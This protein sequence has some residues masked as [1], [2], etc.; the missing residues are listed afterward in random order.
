ML[1]GHPSER[2]RVGT[3]DRQRRT[4][5]LWAKMLVLFAGLLI[6][7]EIGNLFSVQHVFATFWPP[8][9]LLVAMLLISDRRDWPALVLSAIAANI[10]SDLLHDRALLVS[11]GFSFANSAEALFGA[12]LVSG[13]VGARPRLTTM[14]QNL[15]F[16]LL[17]G[18]LAPALG[19]MVGTVVVVL[20]SPG[21][22]VWTTWYAWLIADSL[23]VVLV[24]SSVLACVGV[25]DAYRE[26]PSM[27][28]RQH[29]RPILLSILVAVPFAVVSHIVFTPMG[30]GTSWKFL[31]SPGIVTCGIVG[32]PAGAAL[33]FTIIAL[34]GVQGMVDAASRAAVMSPELSVQVFQAQA[35]FVV[36]GICILTLAGVIAES[37][38]HAQETRESADMLRK[39][40]NS[41]REGVS[42]GRIIRDSEGVPNDWIVLSTNESYTRLTGITDANGR[43]VSEFMP[44]LVKGN[45]EILETFAAVAD[46]GEAR[47]LETYIA[48]VGK[49]MDFSVTSPRS[50]EFLAVFEDATERVAAEEALAAGN[51]RLEKMVYDVAEAMGSVVEARDPYTQGHQLRVAILVRLIGEEMGL[52]ESELDELAMAA[53]LHDIGKLRV[54]AE[55]L[56]KPGQL[57]P[58]EMSLVQ[59]HPEQGYETLRH[60]D[61]PW[62]IADIVRQHHERMD[63]SGYP[64]GLTGD[65]I[66]PPSRILAAADVIEA[67]AS[68]RPY[69]PAVS[70]EAGVAEVVS[71]PD[72]FDVE[73]TAACQRLL[74]RG[75]IVFPKA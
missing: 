75:A 36:W 51:V 13:V 38:H 12:F 20:S 17:A 53:L 52:S 7:A 9:G 62:R 55:I 33:G 56:N 66:L 54:P 43:R 26:R 29:L 46:D 74:E 6:A 27:R 18:V 64:H 58:V 15:A 41:M 39:L 48:S 67:L 23:G 69:R 37:R 8:A 30:G 2:A 63:G 73:V 21:A 19:A 60:I 16:T 34:A 61:F 5:P 35:F 65:E 57:S 70:V 71:H 50:G 31:T 28:I 3:A 22:P 47:V 32:G 45:P 72:W 24:G 40:F 44:S 14:K 10:T 1:L 49:V 11:M 25:W 4:I 42:H 59:E 68:H